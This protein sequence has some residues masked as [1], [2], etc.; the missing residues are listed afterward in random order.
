MFDEA[1]KAF[2]LKTF[3]DILSQDCVS[4]PFFFTRYIFLIRV[5]HSAGTSGNFKQCAASLSRYR[6]LVKPASSFRLQ[7]Q[8]VG[9][10]LRIRHFHKI[11]FYAIDGGSEWVP[12][13]K[14]NHVSHLPQWLG[15]CAFGKM[16]KCRVKPRGFLYM[17]DSSRRVVS[18]QLAGN[19]RSIVLKSTYSISAFCAPPIINRRRIAKCC[20][21]VVRKKKERKKMRSSLQ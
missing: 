10:L 1:S 18:Y 3:R 20:A 6:T 16:V 11:R 4:K 7:L 14:T 13:W 5:L 2:A 17:S 15:L 12:L 19:Q 21:T 8:L 9:L